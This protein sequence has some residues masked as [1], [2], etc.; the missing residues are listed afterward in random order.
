MSIC[1]QKRKQSVKARATVTTICHWGATF[2][3]VAFV[4]N[5]CNPN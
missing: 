4:T 5:A 2:L 1:H 3:A